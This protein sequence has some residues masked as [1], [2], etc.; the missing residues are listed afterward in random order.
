M[1]PTTTALASP[2]WMASIA[3]F[4]ATPNV[5]QAA[6]GAKVRPV[7]RPSIDTW[8]AGVFWMF[9]TRLAETASQ[10][11]R[12]APKRFCSCARRRCF[13]L[14]TLILARS[15]SPSIESPSMAASSRR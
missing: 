1:A 11:G 7:M 8:A 9:H 10:G 15:T 5:E 14:S 12:G 4:R 2:R 13:S 3:S 6:T